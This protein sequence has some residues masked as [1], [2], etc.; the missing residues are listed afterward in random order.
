MVTDPMNAQLQ[1]VMFLKNLGLLGG[2]LAFA[3]FG[4]GAYSVDARTTVDQQTPN[5][6]TTTS[7]AGTVIPTSLRTEDQAEKGEKKAL[8]SG[9]S[10]RMTGMW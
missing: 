10:S 5:V 8:K 3:H 6:G 4:A 9:D 1:Q 7:M 2:A